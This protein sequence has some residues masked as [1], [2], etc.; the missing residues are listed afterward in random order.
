M[1]IHTDT[2]QSKTSTATDIYYANGTKHFWSKRDHPENG[3][4]TLEAERKWCGVTVWAIVPIPLK[5]PIC[6]NYI[7]VYFENNEPTTR[8]EGWVSLGNFYGCG[9]GVWLGS[10]ISNG[11]EASLCIAE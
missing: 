6:K 7:D 5:L 8:S 3:K 2:Q 4:V 10:V 9:P 11:T 1:G